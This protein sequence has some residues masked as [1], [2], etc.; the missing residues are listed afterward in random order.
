MWRY[1][2]VGSPGDGRRGQ[3][4]RPPRGCRPRD[5]ICGRSTRPASKHVNARDRPA[6]SPSVHLLSTPRLFANP[7]PRGFGTTRAGTMGVML[8]RPERRHDPRH[9]G[10]VPVQGRARPGP[11]RGQGQ[12][13]AQPA[14]QLLRAA[15]V[16]DAPDPPDGRGRRDRRVDRGPQRGRGALPRIQPHQAAP[17]PLQ[18]PL[19]G[20]QVVS[21][22]RGHPR[23]GVAAG[24]GAPRGEAQ[25]RPLLRAVRARVRDP[26]DPRPA[27]AHVP[28]P[29]VHEEQVRPPP[30]ARAGRAS[31][32]TSRSARRRA[33]ATSTTRSTTSSSTS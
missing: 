17:A 2:R 33:S 30:P 15:R 5:W 16:A 25:G 7:P 20:R 23:R 8:H 3:P 14:L 18:H 4:G 29:H 9:P 32:R 24:D 26:R 1:P 19:Q 21:V 27:P 11:L 22:P 10:L 31:T 6:A 12:E 28:D 13:P